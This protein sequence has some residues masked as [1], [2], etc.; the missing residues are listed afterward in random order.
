VINIFIEKVEQKFFLE[1][2]NGDPIHNI[3]KYIGGI[4][5]SRGTQKWMPNCSPL[6]FLT[7]I[8]CAFI[9]FYA[10]CLIKNKYLKF[11]LML[12]CPFLSAVLSIT[13]IV[14][15]PW[16]IDTALMAVLFI[17]IGLYL[18]EKLNI[19]DINIIGVIILLVVGILS[20]KYNSV[21]VNFDNNRYGNPILMAIG[22]FCLCIVVVWLSFNLSKRFGCKILQFYGQHTIF[23]MGFDYF[24]GT[25]VKGVLY[26]IGI[27]NWLPVF[28]GKILILT[29]GIIIW[30]AMVNKIKNKKI[31]DI[32]QY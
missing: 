10:V 30:M 14:K 27:D 29:V 1:K 16:N 4:F 28:V 5:Y 22:A 32:L 19:E 8:F 26:K 20:V 25:I 17:W 7:A 6:W 23:I 3:V 21:E 2:A 31:R 15:L 9:I 24:T 18:K 12:F 13:E 11:I